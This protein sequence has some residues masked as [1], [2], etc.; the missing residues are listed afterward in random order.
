MKNRAVIY[1]ISILSVTFLYSCTFFFIPL[2]KMTE[3]CLYTAQVEGQAVCAIP[4]SLPFMAFYMLLPLIVT[5]VLQ[6]LVYREPLRDI[7]FTFKWTPWY[8]FAWLAPVALAYISLS[9]GQLLPGVTLDLHMS[10]YI[11]N[12]AKT[13][14]PEQVEAFRKQA[15]ATNY[16]ILLATVQALVAGITI[17]ALFAFGEEAGW[18]GMMLKHTEGAGFYKASALIGAVWGI[19]HFPVIIQGYNFPDHPVAGVFMMVLFCIALTP[20]MI[21][22]VKKT[23]S[24]IAAAVFHGSINASAGMTVIFLKGG[25]DL[26]TGAVGACSIA[27]L[28]ILNIAL[29]VYDRYYAPENEK[30]ITSKGGARP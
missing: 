24:V 20:P 7:G 30:V 25:N 29:Y 12:L 1:T 21:Y 4:L 8:L 9:I 26:T 14:P 11:E 10:G 22:A 28:V 23:G 13:M 18:R 16:G 3:V 6:K 27:S 17:N 19:W 2:K 5:L 15:E